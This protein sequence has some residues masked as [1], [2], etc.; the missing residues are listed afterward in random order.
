MDEKASMGGRILGYEK[1]GPEKDKTVNLIESPGLKPWNNWTVPMSM[2]EVEPGVRLIMNK[3]HIT[4]GK[5]WKP[6]PTTKDED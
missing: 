2:R 1:R 4:D 6:R 5:D 3:S